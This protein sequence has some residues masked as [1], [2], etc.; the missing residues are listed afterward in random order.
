[1]GH[2][3]TQKVCR[4]NYSQMSVHVHH[5]GY[6]WYVGILHHKLESGKSLYKYTYIYMHNNIHYVLFCNLYKYIFRSRWS[7]RQLNLANGTNSCQT[8]WFW[9]PDSGWDERKSV[10]LRLN[11]S[12][13]QSDAF[14]A[15]WSHQVIS[16]ATTNAFSDNSQKETVT[17][18]IPSIYIYN[19]S[20]S[21]QPLP[22][23]GPG[24]FEINSPALAWH[25]SHT[26][27]T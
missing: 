2:W 13:R 23:P 6:V 19:F 12:S 25:Y 1:M 18:H 14:F 27:G 9:L 24:I 4:K 26:I 10:F 5:N 20:L 22:P 3:T 11:S 7:I 17:S 21:L 15:K 8:R 16:H